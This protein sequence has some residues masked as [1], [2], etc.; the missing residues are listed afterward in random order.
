[1][2]KRRAFN[3]ALAAIG[4]SL[5]P[6]ADVRA[7][8]RFVEGKDYERLAA[9]TP[10]PS[11]GRIEVLEFF[12]Y[13]CTHCNAFEPALEAWIRKLPG[14]V[15]FRRVPVTFTSLHQTH[16]ALFYALEA[17]NLREELHRVVF[18]A[19]HNHRRRLDSEKDIVAFI[20]ERGLD[21][22]KFLEAFKSFAVGAKVRLAKATAEDYR[23]DGVPTLGI[24]RRFTTSGSLAGSH[25][26][27]L[28][29][30]DHLI[31]LAR[32]PG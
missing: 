31:G 30:A 13:G 3:Q 10:G 20:A 7:Q 6:L 25:E 4:F 9:T 28:A 22:A 17:L 11:T 23:I 29:V 21:A 2:M 27:A 15:D 8:A 12:W 18:A 19:L 16:A 5:G 1:M 24:H 14:N 26:R 32:S